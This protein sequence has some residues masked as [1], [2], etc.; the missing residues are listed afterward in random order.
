[1]RAANLEPQ[2]SI[3]LRKLR[4]HE[5]PRPTPEALAL[6][7]RHPVAAV[8]A[9]VRSIHNVGAM[10]R[11]ADATRLSHLYLT[12]F[13]GTPDHRQLHKTALGAQETV[14]W[15]H[16]ADAAALLKRLRAEGYTLAAVEI[17]DASTPV[18]A[19]GAAHFPLAFIVG[20][21]V[22]GVPDGL[23]ALAD[24]ALELP[25]YGA[26]QS[27]NVSVAFGVVAYDL[28]RRYHALAI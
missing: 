22:D 19:L 12:G 15:S 28:V 24:V 18:E 5:I 8:L 1:M 9:D 3:P 4:H 16:H 23:L 21:E 26:K 2:L 13:T 6:L 7:P 25:Q 11:T 27:L 20:N 10:F 17:T 14:P